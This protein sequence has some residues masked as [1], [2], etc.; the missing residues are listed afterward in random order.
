M[1]DEDV[2]ALW[3]LRGAL[4][5]GRWPWEPLGDLL[6]GSVRSQAARLGVD[7]AQ[8]YRWR[9]TG[10]SDSMADRCAIRAGL[11]P[12]IVWADWDAEHLSSMRHASA[13]E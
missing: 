11:H 3:R 5:R 13:S 10:L 12:A 6:G 8:L 1:S 7:D 9:R 4:G 2:E